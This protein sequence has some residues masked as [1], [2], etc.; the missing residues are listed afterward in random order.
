MF[1]IVALGE[2]LIDFTDSGFSPNGM[3]LFERNAGG[4]P[5][6][7]LVAAARFGRSVAF[8]GKVGDDMHGRF[9]KEVLVSEGI[10]TDGMLLD[11]S[12][13]TTLAFVSLDEFGDEHSPLP[14]S[15]VPIPAF[16]RKNSPSNFSIIA[17]CSILAQSL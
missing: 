10:C 13:F 6:N 8:L 7:M 12:V 5:G 11:P 17:G 1:D 4:A 15:Q 3:K 16:D 9:L 2:L 14:A